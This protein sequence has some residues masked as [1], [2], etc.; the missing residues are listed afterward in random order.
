MR[1][2]NQNFSGTGFNFGKNEYSQPAAVN[3]TVPL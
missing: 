1:S 3:A 2:S